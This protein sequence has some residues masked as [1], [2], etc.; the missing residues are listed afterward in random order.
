MGHVVKDDI[1]PLDQK[2][3]NTFDVM[4]IEEYLFK[5]NLVV[6]TMI[7]LYKWQSTLVILQE[8]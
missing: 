2:D 3:N 7:C 1:N 4:H 5:Y 8:S 6:S